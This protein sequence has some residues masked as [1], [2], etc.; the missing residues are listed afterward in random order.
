V[1]HVREGKG[2]KDRV[3]PLSDR[4]LHWIVRYLDEAR[5]SLV[6]HPDCGAL[7]LSTT[8]EALS[9]ETLT[10]YTRQYILDAK[11]GK[12]GSCH[13]IRHSVATMM[14][15]AGASIRH[16]QELLGHVSLTSTEIYT[17]V[18]IDALRAVHA[19]TH[20]TGSQARPAEDQAHAED[21]LEALVAEAEEDD[22]E[23]VA[24]SS[25]GG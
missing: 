21:L 23:P 2:Q 4:A 15:D 22:D 9:P 5:Q 8:G 19:A 20:P 3:L 17:R 10:H 11:L 6:G 14:L 16:I 18:S 24:S 1:L 7:L 13:L 25:R 12:T